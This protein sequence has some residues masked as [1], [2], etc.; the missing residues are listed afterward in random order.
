[1]TRWMLIGSFQHIFPGSAADFQFPVAMGQAWH[2]GEKPLKM[3]TT[4]TDCFPSSLGGGKKS[5]FLKPELAP[6]GVRFAREMGK[7]CEAWRRA[8]G[9]LF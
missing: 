9:L 5:S 3:E 2:A 8:A 6:A 7:R 4:F 1:M